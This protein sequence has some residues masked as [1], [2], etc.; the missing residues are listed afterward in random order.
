MRNGFPLSELLNVL[1][2]N[3]LIAKVGVVSFSQVSFS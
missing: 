2:I 3:G 1:A